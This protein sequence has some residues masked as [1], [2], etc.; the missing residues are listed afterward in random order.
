MENL[1]NI[2]NGN[3]FSVNELADMFGGEKTYGEKSIRT[4]PNISR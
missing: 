3:N 4:I 2:G 1:F